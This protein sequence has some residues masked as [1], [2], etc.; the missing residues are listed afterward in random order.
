MSNSVNDIPTGLRVPAQI[1]LDPKVY[2]LSQADLANLGPGNNLAYTYFKGM[3]AY[4][5]LE[6]T[7]WEWREKGVGETGGL[8]SGDFTY[9]SGLTIFGINYSNKI[10]NFFPLGGATFVAT[11]DQT[12][13]QLEMS[14]DWKRGNRFEA[15]TSA[16]L[17]KGVT[18]NVYQRFGYVSYH[19]PY[20]QGNSVMHQAGTKLFQ[21]KVYNLG[22]NIKGFSSIKDYSPTI[23]ISKYT[24]SIK[25]RTKHPELL[26]GSITEYFNE[27]TWRKGSYKFSKDDDPVRLTRV[28]IQAKYQVIDFG[29]EH[30][31]KTTQVTNNASNFSPEKIFCTRGANLNYSNLI[32]NYSEFE[33]GFRGSGTVINK[34][35][36][37]LQ[38]HIEITVNAIKYLSKPLGRLK[39]ILATSFYPLEVYSYAPGDTVP[40]DFAEL[41]KGRETKI[42][43]KHT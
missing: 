2:K 7:R 42:Y 13:N 11:P 39:M 16:I 23:V 9:P 3:A 17:P 28:P 26:P 6:Q 35:F 10:Y 27:I 15:N 31:F 4:C 36:V 41:G 38:F 19:K 40:F 20:K 21:A 1:P 32:T 37:Y 30:Y 29:Q 18:D 43:F 34:T 14:F 33:A 8:I 22:I 5:A 24:P 25:K 12:L